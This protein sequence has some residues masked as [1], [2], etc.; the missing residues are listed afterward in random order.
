MYAATAAIA[1]A[2]IVTTA[3]GPTT[4]R[5]P[6]DEEACSKNL[7]VI[8]QAIQAYQADHKDLPNWLSDLVPQYLSDTNVLICP[9]CRRTGVTEGPPLGDPNI[10]CSY[11]FEFCPVPLGSGAAKD[12]TRTRREWKRRQMRL[13]GSAVPVVRCRHHR[14]VLNLGFDGVIYES[15]ASWELMFTNRVSARSLTAAALF[16]G[17]STTPGKAAA[18]PRFSA[19]DAAAGP[20]L[21]DSRKSPKTSLV[22]LPNGAAASL[23]SEP[24][25]SS[26]ANDLK[27]EQGPNAPAAAAP[28]TQRMEPAPTTASSAAIPAV[29]PSYFSRHFMTTAMLGGVIAVGAIVLLLARRRRALEWKAPALVTEWAEGGGDVPSSYTVVVGTRSA[30]EPA[31]PAR[32]ASP[33]PQPLI[34]IETPGVT[35]THAEALRRRALAAEQRADRANAV[36]RRGLI[37]HLSQWLKQRLVRKLVT[38]R[39]HLLEAQEAA[40]LKAAAVEVRLA[41][42]EHQIQRQTAAY[43]E[44]IE[45]LTRELIVAKDESRELIRARI[46]QVKAEME[47]ARAKLMAQSNPDDTTQR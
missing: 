47:A 37:P 11:V 44:R 42:I 1:L 13:V 22:E 39:A 29:S 35:Q 46:S 18:R 12:P 6:E 16:A 40:T 43:Q 8:S 15:A 21:I 25:G 33:A 3:A 38:D 26:R 23:A 32:N 20:G 31:P 27:A 17:E 2:P 14:P 34:H 30:T 28:R 4:S 45:A 19:R 9:V 36:I 5:A 10:P 41:R 7:E 24:I